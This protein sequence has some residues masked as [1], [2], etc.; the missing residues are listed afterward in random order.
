MIIS[1]ILYI[2]LVVFIYMT[3]WFVLSLVLKRNDIAD[4]AWGL[5]F[6]VVVVSLWFRNGFDDSNMNISFI[7]VSI[8]TTL[9]GLRLATH[10]FIR[11]KHKKEDFRYKAWRDSW[12]K[13]FYVRSYLQVFLLQ[14]FLMVLVSMSAIVSSLYSNGNYLISNYSYVLFLGVLVWLVGFIFESFGDYQLSSFISNPNNK[15]KIMK[16]GLWKYTRHPNYFGEVIQWWGMFI[17]VC[18]LPYSYISI[19]SP[20][21]ITFLILKVSGIPMLE[22]AYDNNLEFQE[23]KKVTNAFFPWFP[24]N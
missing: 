11:N 15:G 20:L 13:W 18:T 9:W 19:I 22:K 12:G 3:A 4:I 2:S 7:V 8:L 5:G 6:I 14:G 21:T 16:Y 24:K 23:Y 17:I 10:I 1:T